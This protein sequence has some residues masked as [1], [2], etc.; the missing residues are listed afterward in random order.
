MTL[1]A[2]IRDIRAL[3]TIVINNLRRPCSG[4]I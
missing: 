1:G 4:L 2:K 3:Q